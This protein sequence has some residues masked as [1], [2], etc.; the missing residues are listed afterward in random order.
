MAK[1]LK[2]RKFDNW[3]DAFHGL[4]PQ[5][6]QESVRVAA[7]TQVLFVQC[8]AANFGADNKESAERIQGKFSDLAYKCGIYHQL[9]KAL[10]PVE[11][12]Q[13]QEDFSEEELAVYRKYTT[14]GRLLVATLQE[15]GGDKEK[16]KGGLSEN[17][18]KNIPWLM[19]RECCEQHMERWDG[20]GYPAGRKG[21]EISA[22][23]QIVGLAKE[24]DRLCAYTKS[25]TPFDDAF[26]TLMAQAGTAWNPA[27][28]EIF[29]AAKGKCRAV[30]KK[31]IHYTQTLPTT[32]PLVEK[33]KD[34]PMGLQYRPM[35]SDAQGTVVAYEAIPWFVGVASDPEK[36]SLEELEGTLRRKNLTVD[37]SF[38]FLYEAAD[39]VLRIENCRVNLQAVV[40]RMLPDFFTSGTQLQRLLQLFKDQPI[41]KE[42]L[43]LTVPSEL[44][45][46]TT[47]TN[48]EI[49]ERYTR[50]GMCL[51]ADEYD[52]AQLPVEKLKSMGFT[53]V[54]P[55]SRLYGTPE[56]AL[57][58]TQLHQAG[59]TILGGNVESH[60]TLAWL[61][62]CH[63]AYCSGA[64]TG[65]PVS[66]DEMIR[67]ALTREK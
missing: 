49:M 4:G 17:P 19:M 10:V 41:P 59:L 47:K 5:A 66:E 18:T 25:E 7:Y 22:I 52:P 62:D 11:Y 3:D 42:K 48:I 33:K 60:E 31:Y 38:Y 29:K 30:Y 12:Q 50:N 58:M 55:A 61:K 26:K 15:R 46:K 36:N 64:I 63:M 24:L 6:R 45:A 44:I 37:I 13:V 39:A 21:D 23:A 53:H 54:R 2:R 14:D 35:V 34:R 40:L 56:L 9:G 20:S 28:L 65:L 67:D 27:L 8:C 16:M 51:L 1:K 43:I 57:A 32:I